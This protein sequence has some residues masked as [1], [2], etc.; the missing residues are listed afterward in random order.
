MFIPCQPIPVILH[1]GF[2]FHILLPQAIDDDV[3]VDVPRVIV[4]V[5]VRDDQSLVASKEIFRKLLYKSVS[6]AWVQIM[7]RYIP[8]IETNDVVVSH[9]VAFAVVL[10][11]LLV[12]LDAFRVESEGIAVHAALKK[13]IAQNHMSTLITKKFV[14]PFFTFEDQVLLDVRVVLLFDCKVFKNCQADHLPA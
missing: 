12:Q 14:C 13:V 8:W 6:P 4:A 7:I 5:C 10:I 9:D 2:P 1:E 3:G 11:K